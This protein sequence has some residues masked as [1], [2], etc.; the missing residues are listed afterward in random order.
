MEHYGVSLT[1]VRYQLRNA[2]HRDD[3]LEMNPDEPPDWASWQ[4]S[5]CYS[6]DLLKDVPVERAAEFAGIVC[7][8]KE[9]GFITHETASAYL[10][11]SPEQF[12]ETLSFIRD[13]D[14]YPRWFAQSG[15]E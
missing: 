10:K 2:L 6:T 8:A 12:Q 7:A 14:L 13:L 4:G 5:E 1:V 3:M 15:P 9:K 11:L